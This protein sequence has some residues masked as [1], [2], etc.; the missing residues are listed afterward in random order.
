MRRAIVASILLLLAPGSAADEN[1]A[2]S[3]AYTEFTLANGHHVILHECSRS[4]CIIRQGPLKL[5]GYVE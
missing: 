1:V 2:L 5:I 3:V 4:D